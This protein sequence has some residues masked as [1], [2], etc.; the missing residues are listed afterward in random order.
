MSGGTLKTDDPVL[1][2]ASKYDG[3]LGYPFNDLC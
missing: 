1:P 3:N 2:H